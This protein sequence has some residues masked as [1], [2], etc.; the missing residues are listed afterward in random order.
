MEQETEANEALIIDNGSFFLRSF[1]FSKFLSFS[2]SYLFS[3][4]GLIPIMSQVSK[5]ETWSILINMF[6]SSF[7][8]PLIS[9]LIF[10][11]SH[12]HSQDDEEKILQNFVRAEKSKFFD[13]KVSTEGRERGASPNLFIADHRSEK[14]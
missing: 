2:F 10:S 11:F 8:L 3:G 9:F 13:A 5:S 12:F 4:L 7:F 14:G 6:L 1:L